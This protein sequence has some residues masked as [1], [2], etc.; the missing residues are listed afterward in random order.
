[1]G[2]H[3][4]IVYRADHEEWVISLIQSGLGISIMPEWD[5]TEG[6]SYVPLAK[7]QPVR[8]IG[9]QWCGKRNLDLVK[10]FHSFVT[11]GTWFDDRFQNI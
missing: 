6:L 4:H 10:L 2:V 5:A 1:M 9:L 3:P 8:R 11:Q 7:M